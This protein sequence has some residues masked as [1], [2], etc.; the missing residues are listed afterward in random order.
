MSRWNRV[1]QHEPIG[2][3]VRRNVASVREMISDPE[4]LARFDAAHPESAMPA[5]PKPRIRRPVDGQPQQATEHQE[6]A[7]VIKWWY[8][9]HSGYQLPVF[10]LF[11]CP[12][13]G[14]RDAITGSLLK[15]E[16]VRPGAPDL[17]LAKPN[18]KY[19]GLYI[20]MKRIGGAKPSDDQIAMIDYL[21]SVGYLATVHYGA[22]SAI[23]EIKRYLGHDEAMALLG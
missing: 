17:I 23:E 15:A 18:K 13:G 11:A 5:L 16:G 21:L 7:A 9:A 3:T 14:A 19:A 4:K 2:V 10:A 22:E 1:K 6:Q 12:N 20:E 8:L